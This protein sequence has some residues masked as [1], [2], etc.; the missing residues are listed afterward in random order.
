MSKHKG[1]TT[2]ADARAA[3]DKLIRRT[4]VEEAQN[5]GPHMGR[6]FLDGTAIVVTDIPAYMQEIE[7]LID[8]TPSLRERF[9]QKKI[10]DHIEKRVF[11]RNHPDSGATTEAEFFR[12]LLEIKP[13][14]VTVR[15]PISGVRLDGELRKFSLGPFGFGYLDDIEDPIAN[16][17]I[18]GMYVEIR[19]SGLYDQDLA[20][21]KADAAFIDFARLITFLSGRQDRSVLIRLGLPLLQDMTPLLVYVS[22]SSYQMQIE[23]GPTT[24]F[25][26][27]NQHVEKVPLNHEVFSSPH[28]LGQLWPLYD[29]WH[30]GEKLKDLE[31]RTLNAALALGESSSTSDLRNS[32]I[33][34]CVALEMLF[35]RDD[36]AL[37]QKSIGSNVSDLFVFIAAKDLESRKG[38]AKLT[39]RVYGMRSA[40]VHGGDK[41]ASEENKAVNHL[42]R[43]AIA[44]LLTNDRFKSVKQLSELFEMMQDAQYSYDV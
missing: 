35:S 4:S 6:L 14:S 39:K 34:T 33:Y 15:A 25:S 32:V 21:E 17:S 13:V 11:N 19:V 1:T 26:I 44:E 20:R 27:S 23:G 2:F 41:A 3:I 28:G 31:K 43:A 40:I 37:F 29:R 22:T 8:S 42:L 9:G 36:G 5:L 38:L 12:E 7:K 24:S 30:R 16:L 10:L 18:P